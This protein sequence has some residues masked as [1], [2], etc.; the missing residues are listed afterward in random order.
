VKV[1]L[2]CH[3]LSAARYAERGFRLYDLMAGDAR[4][5]RSLGQEHEMLFW[6]RGQRNRVKLRAE[7]AIVGIKRRLTQL[8]GRGRPSN[9]DR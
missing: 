3:V 4:Y 9:T 5:K 2:L 7:T 1:G 6:I 8:Y